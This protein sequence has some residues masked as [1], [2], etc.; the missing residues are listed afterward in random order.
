MHAPGDR[1]ERRLLTTPEAAHFLRLS[2]R[3]LER[4]RV[5]GTG[6]RYI[7]AGP[8]RRARVLYRKED[9]HAWLEGF[10][11]NSTAEYER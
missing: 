1:E 10:R 11:F 3:T 7:K 6:P 8:G 5:E 4:Y 9:L 2:A